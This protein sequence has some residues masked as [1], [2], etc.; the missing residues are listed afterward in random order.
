MATINKTNTNKNTVELRTELNS[1]GIQMENVYVNDRKFCCVGYVSEKD[2]A[3]CLKAIQTAV[4][5]SENEY[6][7]MMKLMTIANLGDKEISPDKEIEVCG[8]K[9]FISYANKTAYDTNGNEIADCR[10]LACDL[11]DE[12]IEAIIV[13]RVERVLG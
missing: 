4:D 12:A 5:T 9:V 11:P 7:A 2:K 3:A 1:N 13:P 8:I 6:E 10:E